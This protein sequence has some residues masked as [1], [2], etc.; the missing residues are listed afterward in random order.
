MSA[1]RAVNSLTDEDMK[2]RRAVGANRIVRAQLKAE[3]FS[4]NSE[5]T[6][7]I[8]WMEK[9]TAPE[10][11]KGT[12]KE[13]AMLLMDLTKASVT[14]T[15][16]SVAKTNSPTMA[17]SLSPTDFTS[18]TDGRGPSRTSSCQQFSFA[19]G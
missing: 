13:T 11:R 7:A 16:V 8:H 14:K 9:N 2:L 5:S 3:T 1:T 15:K 18:I 10:P 4:G 19:S 12:R 17:A 6:G